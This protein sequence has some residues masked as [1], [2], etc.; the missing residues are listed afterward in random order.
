LLSQIKVIWTDIFL[1]S[2]LAIYIAIDLSGLA[3]VKLSSTSFVLILEKHAIKM[4]Y[5][6]N[7]AF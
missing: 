5:S 7:T 3:V 4:S 1:E 2:N 6:M